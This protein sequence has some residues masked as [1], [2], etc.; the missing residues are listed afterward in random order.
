MAGFYRDLPGEKPPRLPALLGLTGAP[1]NQITHGSVSCQ[2][3]RHWD[4]PAWEH[5]EFFENGWGQSRSQ[6]QSPSGQEASG[7]EAVPCLSGLPIDYCKKQEKFS[8][9]SGRWSP[10]IGTVPRGNFNCTTDKQKL[11][12]L[13]QTQQ[14]IFA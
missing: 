14:P 6:G 12:F 7:Q 1:K 5:Y 2:V 10:G 13:S 8:D 9:K 3:A 4:S 11:Q